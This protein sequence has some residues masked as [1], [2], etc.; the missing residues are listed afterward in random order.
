MPIPWNPD[1]ASRLITERLTLEG[2]LLPILHALQEAFGCVP[3]PATAMI[4]TSLNLSRAEVH[5][6][7]TFYHDFRRAPAGRVVVRLC[8]SEACQAMG[9]RKAADALL[10]HLKLHWGE[11]AQDG[12]V[13]VDPVY[14]L[15]LC[16]VA[17]AALIGET[18][19]GRVDADCLIRQV[20]AAR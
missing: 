17:P 4:A 9:G 10:A 6:V 3:E 18:P 16:A 11:T 15:G 20:E 14:C 19:L 7:I 13:T 1:L 5:G 8:R 2:P 12:S